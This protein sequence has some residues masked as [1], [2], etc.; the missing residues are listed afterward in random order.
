MKIQRSTLILALVAFGLSS[1]IYIQQRLANNPEVEIRQAGAEPLFAFDEADIT[2]F[3]IRRPDLTLSLEKRKP[4]NSGDAV[5]DLEADTAAAVQP[6]WSM[7]APEQMPASDGAVAFLLNLLATGDRRDSFRITN[8]GQPQAK[9]QQRLAEFGLDTPIAQVELTLA[10]GTSHRLML[11]DS[12]FDN[13]GIYAVKDADASSDAIEIFLVN[14]SLEPAVLRP[15]EE[16]RYTAELPDETEAAEV[17]DPETSAPLELD[18]LTGES[19]LPVVELEPDAGNGEAEA[20]ANE[21][22]E[23]VSGE[24]VEL[25]V[26]DNISNVNN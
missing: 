6:D 10:D 4:A 17:V 16:W 13:S 9:T 26:E 23:A 20:S 15:L 14:S 11:G 24:A 8:D 19:E 2:Q 7:T 3:T 18:A 12:N 25:P 1:G 22:P 21:S 5:A